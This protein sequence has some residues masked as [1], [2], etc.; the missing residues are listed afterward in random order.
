MEYQRTT[1]AE[2]VKESHLRKTPAEICV[3]FRNADYCQREIPT[4]LSHIR[5]YVEEGGLLVPYLGLLHS[6]HSDDR[7]RLLLEAA[8]RSGLVARVWGEFNPSEIVPF[9]DWALSKQFLVHGVEIGRQ[10]YDEFHTI[11]KILKSVD[12]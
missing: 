9:R 7:P 11:G 4:H 12:K 5:G 1:L 8:V 3:V 6:K 2:F 10:T